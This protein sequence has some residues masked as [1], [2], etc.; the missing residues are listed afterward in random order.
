MIGIFDSGTGGLTIAE[1]SIEMLD[2]EAF[3]YLGDH[4]RA[5][6]GHRSNQEIL[7]FTR[8]A[9]SC[10]FDQGCDLVVLACNTAAA[11]ALRSLQQ[12]WLPF[13]APDKRILGILVPTVEAVT[14][15]PWKQGLCLENKG[16]IGVFAT[17]KTVQSQAYVEEIRKRAPKMKV[18]QIPCPG[19][20]SAIE[21]GADDET[22][23][24]LI[25]PAVEDMKLQSDG[26]LNAVL[27]G[28]THYPL[29]AEHFKSA[30]ESDIPIVSQ[31]D[32]TADALK[33]YL[34]RHPHFLK[35]DRVEFGVRYLTTG[36]V[37]QATKT[38][39]RLSALNAEFE[40]QDLKPYAASS[41]SSAGATSPSMARK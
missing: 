38:A 13:H 35:G 18:I 19:L 26:H 40:A 21:R 23:M 24:S 31:P 10:L 32:I 27:L 8:E 17:P 22:I 14:G 9:V 37:A 15:V 3:L 2:G 6:Y 5:P 1:K 25:A 16:V 34:K 28:C 33:S 41:L 7:E 4:A 30:L 36:D 29:V 39:S 12:H 20:V 11:V